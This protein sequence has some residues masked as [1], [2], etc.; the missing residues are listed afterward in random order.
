MTKARFEQW[1]PW[2]EEHVCTGDMERSFLR[3]LFH[4]DPH[5]SSL[6]GQDKVIILQVI[7]HRTKDNTGVLAY[8]VKRSDT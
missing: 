4:T 7:M 6:G 8:R 5:L 1:W 3:H 2:T